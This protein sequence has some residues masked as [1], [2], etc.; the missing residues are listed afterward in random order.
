VNTAICAAAYLGSCVELRRI[1][2][3][4]AGTL[5]P[6]GRRGGPDRL[7]GSVKPEIAGLKP[8]AQVLALMVKLRIVL[9]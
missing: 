9:S 8:S 5:P 2:L 4:I 6:P 1:S 7:L 3:D